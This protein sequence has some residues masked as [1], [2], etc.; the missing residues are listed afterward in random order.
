MMMYQNNVPINQLPQPYINPKV[1][2]EFLFF[3]NY[4][5]ETERTF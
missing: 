5:S 2:F 3:V 4:R 1:D